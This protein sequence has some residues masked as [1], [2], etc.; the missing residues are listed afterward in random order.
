[1]SITS[2]T[3]ARQVRDQTAEGAP[4]RKRRRRTMSTTDKVA[5]VLMAAVPTLAVVLLIWLPALASVLLGFTRWEGIGGLDT[6]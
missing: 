1:M 3:P 2:P 5:V 6:I 4:T